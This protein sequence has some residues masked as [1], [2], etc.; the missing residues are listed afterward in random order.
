M[1]KNELEK[2]L[3]LQGQNHYHLFKALGG[4]PYYKGTNIPI[5][6]NLFGLVRSLLMP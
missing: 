4:E 3:E 6:R 5:V 1:E 2:D